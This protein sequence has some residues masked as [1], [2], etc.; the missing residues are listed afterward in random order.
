MEHGRVAVLREYGGPIELEE[1]EVPDPE[2][3]ALVVRV[4]QAGICGSDLNIMR[5]VSPLNPGGRALG[6]E[7]G[8]GSVYRLGAGLTTD[9][10]GQPLAEGDRIIHSGVEPCYRCSV[11]L[12]GEFAWCPSYSPSSRTPGKFPF[13]L[14]TYADYLYLDGRP[15]F[16]IPDGIPTRS[17]PSST[18]RS[19]P[20]PI[21]CCGSAST[22]AST[23]LSR[24]PAASGSTRSGCSGYSAPGTSSSWI[25][26]PVG[27]NSPA[28]WAPRIP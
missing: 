1:Y 6:H 8:F 7:E 19:G 14:G 27:S 18:A 11:C 20:S 28:R 15:I 3:G 25:A 13:F 24:A 17:S 2:P 16:K 10:L 4:E 9:S 21:R 22:R 26:S 5:G 12:R 23:W